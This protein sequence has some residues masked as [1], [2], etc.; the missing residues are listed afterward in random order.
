MIFATLVEWQELLE[1]VLASV[2][3]GVGVTAIFAV[4][5]WGV[6][7]FADLS[8]DEKTLAASVAAVVASAALACVVAAVV[9]GILAM[10]KK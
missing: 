4:A 3:A 10:T 2:L 7:R 5:I 8:R 9:V 6:G 1:T